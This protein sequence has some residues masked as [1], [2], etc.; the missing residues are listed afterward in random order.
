MRISDWIQTCALPISFIVISQELQPPEVPMSAVPDEDP[1]PR[2]AAGPPS[3]ELAFLQSVFAQP[4]GLRGRAP[5]DAADGP[6]AEAIG[7]ASVRERGCRDVLL[8]V[9]GGSCK[10]QQIRKKLCS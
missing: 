8:P 7:R 5:G 10:E 6:A 1:C 3:L 2:A 9:V 4:S